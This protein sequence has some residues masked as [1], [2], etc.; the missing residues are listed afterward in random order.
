MLQQ[1]YTEVIELKLTIIGCWGGYPAPGEATSAYLLEKDHYKLLIDIGS[2]AVSRLQKYT[3]IQEIDAVI[4]SH[5]HHDH[6]ADLGVLQY[7]KLIDSYITGETN[8]L[9]IYGHAEDEQAFR[10]LTHDCTEGIAYHGHENVE[11]GPFSITFLQTKHPVPCYGMRLTDGE[12]TIVYTADTSYQ[13]DWISFSSKA[14]VL[15]TD[16]NFY[17]HQDGTDAGHMNS[18]EGALIAEKAGVK[19][20]ILSHLPQ[21]GSQKQ[22]VEEAKEVYQGTV[23]LAKEGFIW[24]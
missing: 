6:V 2:G 22:L 10:L 15:I 14:D 7:A 5:Y 19:E 16:C 24:T 21:Y 9:P 3:T 17:G 8:K 23:H 11:I 4:L 20:L 13:D 18:R 1:I 12:Q